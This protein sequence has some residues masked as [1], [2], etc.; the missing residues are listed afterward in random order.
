MEK[1][2]QQGELGCLT[3]GAGN[4][5]EQW[6]RGEEDI[7][8]EVEFRDVTWPEECRKGRSMSAMRGGDAT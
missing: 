1:L 2:H 8:C 6:Q 5:A 3:E 4:Q 7:A